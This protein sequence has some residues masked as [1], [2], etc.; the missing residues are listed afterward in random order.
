VRGQALVVLVPWLLLAAPQR[1]DVKV[2]KHGSHVPSAWYREGGPETLRDCRGCHVYEKGK[3]PRDPQAV[4]AN[5]HARVDGR[6]GFRIVAE[7]PFDRDLSAVRNAGSAVFEHGDH[8]RLQC[9]ECHLPQNGLED[10]LPITAGALSCRDCHADGGRRGFNV[11]DGVEGN[12]DETSLSDAGFAAALNRNEQ[13]QPDQLGPFRHQDHLSDLQATVSLAA[14]LAGDGACMTCHEA[15]KDIQGAAFG[16]MRFTTKACAK[17]HSSDRG[18]LTFRTD[19]A[20]SASAAAGT[21]AHSDHVRVAKKPQVCSEDA[22]KLVDDTGCAACHGLQVTAAGLDTWTMKLGGGTGPLA[23]DYE[24]CVTCHTGPEWQTKSHGQWSTCVGC[25]D[26][27]G[28]SLR[29]A[30]PTDEIRRSDATSFTITVHAHPHITGAELQSA[31]GEACAKCHFAPV[32]TLPSRIATKK[33]NH[34]THLPKAPTPADC[35]KCHPGLAGSRAAGSLSATIA[36]AAGEADAQRSYTLTA[37]NE[38]HRGAVLQATEA[39]PAARRVPRFAHADHIDKKRSNGEV[40]SCASCHQAKEGGATFTVPD[41]DTCKQCH[42]HDAQRAADTKG[43]AGNDVTS[44]QLCHGDT[45]P[46]V[47]GSLATQRL[48][49]TGIDGA[50]FHVAGGRQCETCHVAPAKVWELN[51]NVS[52]NVAKGALHTDGGDKGAGTD[53]YDCHWGKVQSGQPEISPEER[54]RRGR[55]VQPYG[56]R[57]K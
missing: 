22:R 56:R 52:G 40:L 21:F 36:A 1:D 7:P 47:G 2:F 48:C 23:A 25:H 51:D 37:C 46:A 43:I 50:Q 54:T 5:C 27:G 11:V 39:E 26:F 8:L 4:C 20:A 28:K 41:L 29:D 45:V 12:I 44:C 42:G 18:A 53:C 15:V 38:C 19:K 57:K 49:L 55:S 16:A 13:M 33:F 31:Q 3:D 10:P 35:A 17:C 6:E 9:R 34:A 14:L 32:A 30:R 24:G